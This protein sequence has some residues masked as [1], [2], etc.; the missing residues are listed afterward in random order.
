MLLNEGLNWQVEDFIAIDFV[1]FDS[2]NLLVNQVLIFTSKNA[3]FGL[4]NSY[5]DINLENHTVVCVG[6]KTKNELM[7]FG[8][9]VTHFDLSSKHLADWIVRQDKFKNLVLFCG[10]IRRE[11]LKEM[12]EEMEINYTEI[13]VYRTILTPVEIEDKQDGIVFFSPSS[14]QSFIKKNNMPDAIAFCIGNTTAFEA[15]KYFKVVKVSE[16]PSI[17]SVMGNVN[18]YY[19]IQ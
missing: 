10:N 6:E 8:V 5:P 14:I 11:E 16:N 4:F 19:G 3:V 12:T 7:N 13:M 18:A 1:D 2:P 17:E 9:E 15:S